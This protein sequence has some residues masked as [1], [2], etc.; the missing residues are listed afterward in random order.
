MTTDRARL[1]ASLRTIQR[2]IAGNTVCRDAADEIETLMREKE[3]LRDLAKDDIIESN[4]R[5]IKDNDRLR[6]E[7]EALR[8]RF[9]SAENA[10]L[11]LA[12]GRR[13]FAR[14]HFKIYSPDEVAFH[15]CYD[16]SSDNEELRKLNANLKQ[17]N[18]K[19]WTKVRAYQDTERETRLTEKLAW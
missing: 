7:S 18:E 3:A 17:E 5:L 19:L 2:G 6:R 4:E 11:E 15:E 16:E 10:L 8:A 9:V 1:C 14:E 12:E 13:K